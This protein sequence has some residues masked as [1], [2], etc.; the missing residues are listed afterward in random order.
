MV[1]RGKLG[2]GAPFLEELS[3]AIVAYGFVDG[4]V[5]LRSIEGAMVGL[6]LLRNLPNYRHSL[7]TKVLEYLAHGVP[8]IT[9]PLP[10]AHDIVE[11]SGGGIVVPFDDPGAVAEAIARMASG[12]FRREC[13]ENGDGRSAT[14]TP[15]LGMPPG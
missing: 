9:T 14:G 10:E 2:V 8:V 6:S 15:G 7:P 5:A 1:H 13:G 3:P 12:S 11:E 4:P